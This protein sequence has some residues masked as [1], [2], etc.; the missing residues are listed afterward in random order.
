MGGVSFPECLQGAGRGGTWTPHAVE[1]TDLVTAQAIGAQYEDHHLFVAALRTVAKRSSGVPGDPHQV[2]HAA[3]HHG[4]VIPLQRACVRGELEISDSDT[5]AALARRRR[6]GALKLSV[7]AADVCE[8]FRLAGVRHAI[9]KGPAVAIAYEDSDREF[10]DLDILVDPEQMSVAIAALEEHGAWVLGELP[11]PRPDGVGELAVG[12][13]RGVTVDLHADL[14]Q[15]ADVRRA[16]RLPAQ[17]LLARVTSACVIGRQLPVLDPEDNLIHVAM[18]T[19]IAG[20]DRLVWLMDLDALVH[21]GRMQ[22]AT[23]VDRARDAR[24]ALVVG[25]MLER[26]ADVLGAPVPRHVLRALQ[27]RGAVWAL[28]LRSFEHWRPTAANYG[29]GLHGQV[30]GTRHAAKHRDKPGDARPTD[31]DRCHRLRDERSAPSLA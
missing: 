4:I 18:H 27:R 17:P 7:A 20:G 6:A 8:W 11:W 1:N 28:L 5:L 21:Q 14:I 31:L 13:E 26:A 16:F 30:L 9:L 29:R 23:L 3:A 10:V 19:M 25:V 22:L 24:A 15:H 2:T 12:L